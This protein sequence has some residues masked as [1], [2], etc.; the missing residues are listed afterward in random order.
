MHLLHIMRLLAL[1]IMLVGQAPSATTLPQVPF[2]VV[3]V[4]SFTLLV[5]KELV[6]IARQAIET[7][8][9]EYRAAFLSACAQHPDDLACWLVQMQADAK[10]RSA[11]RRALAAQPQ[12]TWM[13][14]FQSGTL[15]Y[16]AWLDLGPNKRFHDRT[17]YEKAKPLLKAAYKAHP[18]PLTLLMW[19]E[20]SNWDGSLQPQIPTLRRELLH[21]LAGEQAFRLFRRAEETHWDNEIP[22]AQMTP[23]ENRRLLASWLNIFIPDFERPRAV[24]VTNGKQQPIFTHPTPELEAK[25]RYLLAWQQALKSANP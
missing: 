10:R 12:D 2:G 8:S 4:V 25:R 23:A 24:I 20:F 22:R 19:A 7:P 11:E 3:D 17:L 5:P 14:Q 6:P 18:A 16:Y 15:Y 13:Y 1:V 9:P 21:L